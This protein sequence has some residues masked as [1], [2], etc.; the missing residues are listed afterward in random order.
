ME[1]QKVMN[2]F[3][4]W[5]F[6]DF[7]SRGI[8]ILN[9]KSELQKAMEKHRRQAQEK[10]EERREDH[11]DFEK[12]L[13]ERAQRLIKVRVWYRNVLGLSFI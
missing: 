8:N 1:Q 2:K 3:P 10:L 12:I 9:N 11:S 13:M 5:L 7:L 6:I 4:F